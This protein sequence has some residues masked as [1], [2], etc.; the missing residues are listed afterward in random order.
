MFERFTEKARR[1]IFF[2][3]YEASDLGSPYIETEH[4]LLA[5]TREDKNVLQQA[6]LTTRL[7][8]ETLQTLRARLAAKG[9]AP[10]TPPDLPLSDE[11][12]R[13]LL[14]AAEE[15]DALHD[16]QIDVRHLVLGLLR[17]ENT[18]A[19]ELLREL[20]VGLASAREKLH[21][22]APLRQPVVIHGRARDLTELRPIVN[23]LRR[24]YWDKQPWKPIDRDLLMHRPSGRVAFYHGQPYNSEEFEVKRGASTR[25]YCELCRWALY[26]TSDPEHGVGYTNGRSWLCTE[27]GEK[28][29]LPPEGGETFADFT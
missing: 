19:A 21:P 16:S 25:D 5:V 1:V 7:T 10:A 12:K 2:A 24:F 29:L 18:A 6:G 13:A 3:R 11:S 9:K 17:Q 28:F 27:C 26:E 23:E 15:A 4:L 8:F 20:G 14:Y 22:V